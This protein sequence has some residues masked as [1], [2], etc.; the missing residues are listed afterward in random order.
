M[1][2]MAA[3]IVPLPSDLKKA[4][5]GV[6]HDNSTNKWFETSKQWCASGQL[7]QQPCG[8][9]RG[10]PVGRAAT[11]VCCLCRRALCD[12][13][14]PQESVGWIASGAPGTPLACSSHSLVCPCCSYAISVFVNTVIVAVVTLLLLLSGCVP[15]FIA[16]TSS[17]PETFKF[18]MQGYIFLP[19]VFL[20]HICLRQYRYCWC[21]NTSIAS[22]WVCAQVITTTSSVPETFKFEMQGYIFFPVVFLEFP[23]TAQ[24]AG[25]AL[26][27][28]PAV[29]I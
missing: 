3:R 5:T 25:V 21:C 10:G 29:P 7:H 19:V 4:N 22:L 23:R 2:I 11:F 1:A 13:P 20:C 6:H 8:T 27:F 14:A 15:N 12:L 16:T 9:N 17:V 24:P 28:A 26:W 18:E